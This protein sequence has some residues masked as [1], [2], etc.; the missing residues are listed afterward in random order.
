MV[1]KYALRRSRWLR[2]GRDANVVVMS[3]RLSCISF[4]QARQRS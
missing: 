1:I 2:L 4:E 3:G